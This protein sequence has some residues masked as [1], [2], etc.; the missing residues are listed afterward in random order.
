MQRE[1]LKSKIKQYNI[2]KSFVRNTIIYEI[3]LAR[4]NYSTNL[5]LMAFFLYLF[6]T[7]VIWHV[8]ILLH[9]HTNVFTVKEKKNTT[10]KLLNFI[11]F[12]TTW[13]ICKI[14][15]VSKVIVHGMKIQR[16]LL[17]VDNF[18]RKKMKIHESNSHRNFRSFHLKILCVQH[19]PTTC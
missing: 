14:V 15:V 19:L 9:S 10:S 2:I 3:S 7:T 17:C 16:I 6:F 8:M 4:R 13:K 11:A 1:T 5:S 18:Y 12:T